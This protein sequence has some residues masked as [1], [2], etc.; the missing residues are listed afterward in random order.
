M[1]ARARACDDWRR[2]ARRTLPRCWSRRSARCHRCQRYPSCSF[3]ATAAA[4][5]AGCRCS[6]RAGC[7][8]GPASC[9]VP[10]VPAAPRHPAPPRPRRAPRNR[11]R[12]TPACS[13]RHPSQGRSYLPIRGACAPA[14]R[15]IAIIVIVIV[16]IVAN[17][18]Q[19]TL[20]PRPI[21]ARANSPP[22]ASRQPIGLRAG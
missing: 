21:D 6:S 20:H 19:P 4:A 22:A 3:P 9:C 18:R 16:I 12:S 15:H 7:S 8:R 11:R 13:P 1:R 17:V 10:C 14:R 2:Q 5:A